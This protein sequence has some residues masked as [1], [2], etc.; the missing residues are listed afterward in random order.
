MSHPVEIQIE[1]H[2]SIDELN[3]RIETLEHD[4]KR[5]MMAWFLD[6]QVA[7]RRSLLMPKKNGW[8]NFLS[9]IIHGLP[10]RLGSLYS[11]NSK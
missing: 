4:T 9:K 7:D 10:R 2:M 1:H 3:K 8:L 5:A 6:M 11:M